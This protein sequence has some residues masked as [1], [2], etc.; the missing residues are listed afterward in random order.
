M[1]I[2]IIYLK[3]LLK[4]TDKCFHVMEIIL[5]SLNVANY[6]IVDP[7]TSYNEYFIDGFNILFDKMIIF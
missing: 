6:Y 4:Y 2:I 3:I 7:Y 5:K 1:S